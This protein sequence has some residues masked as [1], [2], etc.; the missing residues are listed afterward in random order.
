LQREQIAGMRSSAAI[1]E[2]QA[3]DLNAQV[4]G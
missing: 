1:A 4:G 2:Q 3:K